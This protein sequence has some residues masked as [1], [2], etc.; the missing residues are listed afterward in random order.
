MCIYM[1]VCAS[2]K[3]N[4]NRKKERGT[5]QKGTPAL[6]QRQ[7]EEMKKRGKERT[8]CPPTTTPPPS[9]LSILP[10]SL[11]GLNGVVWGDHIRTPAPSIHC[12]PL[13]PGCCGLGPVG[14]RQGHEGRLCGVLGVLRLG[15]AGQP[16]L[17]FWSC[18]WSFNQLIHTKPVSCGHY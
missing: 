10:S 8:W 2:M 15:Q 13:S 14:A 1:T 5:G 3:R 4:R 6:P 7:R 17:G 11:R 16:G 18:T 9:T 12:S